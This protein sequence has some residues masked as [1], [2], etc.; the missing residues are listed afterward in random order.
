MGDLEKALSD[1]EKE[2]ENDHQLPKLMK[3]G[4]YGHARIL[5]ISALFE[6]ERLTEAERGK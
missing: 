5:L 1:F 2:V 6:L 4:Q 3:D